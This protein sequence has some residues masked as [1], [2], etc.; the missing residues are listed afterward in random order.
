MKVMKN[1]ALDISL[2][3]DN[4]QKDKELEAFKKATKEYVK[5]RGLDLSTSFDVINLMLVLFAVCDIE[6]ETFDEFITRLNVIHLE[7]DK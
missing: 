5:S 4:T 3:T 2:L 6:R 7:L 1:I